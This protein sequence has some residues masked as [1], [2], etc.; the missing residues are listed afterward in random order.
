MTR[1]ANLMWHRLLDDILTHGEEVCPRGLRTKELLHHTVKVDMARPVVTRKERGLNYQF[2]AA[3]ALW[4]LAGRND[5]DS[6]AKFVPKMRQFSDNGEVLAGAYG[7]RIV[8]QL[9]YVVNTLK[10][11]PDTR[12]AALTVWTP[13]PGPSK[14]I[15]C[16]VS[17]VF[18]I[19]RC[20][21]TEQ[22]NLHLHVHMRSSDAWLGI[23]YDVFSFSMVGFYVCALLGLYPGTLTLSLT[24]NH[25]YEQHWDQAQEL[26]Q[27]FSDKIDLPSVPKEVLTDWPTLKQNLE[28][29]RDYPKVDPLWNIRRKH[30]YP[31]K[32]EVI[33]A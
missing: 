18:N 27:T 31:V 24:S 16:T 28:T 6:L 7:P 17:M 25:L 15:P 2:M 23:P 13:C 21:E 33:K 11:D 4:I 5:V 3:E 1:P 10:Q 8:P 12:Q 20:S 22:E 26:L 32:G 14:D 29:L 30:T 19:R 9:P